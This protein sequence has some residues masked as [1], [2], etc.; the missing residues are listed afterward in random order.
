MYVNFFLDCIH[1]YIRMCICICYIYKILIKYALLNSSIRLEEE[2]SLNVKVT[3]RS[4]VRS[5]VIIPHI[6]IQFHDQSYFIWNVN[7]DTISQAG[8]K[9]KDSR[10]ILLTLWRNTKSISA[11]M[12]ILKCDG[13]TRDL[14]IKTIREDLIPHSSPESGNIARILLVTPR[15][16][17]EY[18]I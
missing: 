16:I 6:I 9:E 2:L 17:T 1:I 4:E 10:F 5:I 8:R 12:R 7:N 3:V 18:A 15:I 11:A 14:K 13:Y